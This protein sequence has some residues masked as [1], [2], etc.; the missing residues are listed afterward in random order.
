M[1]LYQT[2]ILQYYFIFSIL[3][4]RYRFT[5]LFCCCINFRKIIAKLILN[6][7]YSF[8]FQLLEIEQLFKENTKIKRVLILSVEIDKVQNIK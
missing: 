2:V 3:E 7:V 8:I 6:I 1:L 4:N 5:I